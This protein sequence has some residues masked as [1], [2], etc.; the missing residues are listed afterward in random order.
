MDH[1]ERFGAFNNYLRNELLHINA[2]LRG[3][4]ILAA[5]PNC[6]VGENVKDAIHLAIDKHKLFKQRID[7]I[8]GAMNDLNAND[9]YSIFD[10]VIEIDD[11][12]NA[13]LRLAIEE[14][15]DAANLF[16]GHLE[17]IGATDLVLT[18][19]VVEL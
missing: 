19:T 12:V 3:L 14:I 15:N 2:E 13:A 8:V 18:G 1:K 10:G 4:S 16:T 5:A 9:Y 6:S 7:T 17:D 11:D